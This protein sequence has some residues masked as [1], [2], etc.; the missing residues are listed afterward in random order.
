MERC[1]FPESPFDREL[2]LKWMN[3]IAPQIISNL[4]RQRDLSRP[5]WNSFFLSSSREKANFL[6]TGP[7]RQRKVGRALFVRAIHPTQRKEVP[8]TKAA[9]SHICCSKHGWLNQK[10]GLN[11][12]FLCD[13]TGAFLCSRGVVQ[14][15]E[16][17]TRFNGQCR[18][19]GKWSNCRKALDPV[20][21][22]SGVLRTWSPRLNPHPS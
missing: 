18:N 20:Q 4:F 6:S 14:E 5:K 9:F 19:I 7:W 10:S 12:I 2:F 22:S 16:R 17:P 1:S 21:S 15:Q 13:S 11:L 8:S 3:R